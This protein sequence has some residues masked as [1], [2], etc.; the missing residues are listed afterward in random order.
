MQK[1][2]N[3]WYIKL[4]SLLKLETTTRHGRTNLAGVI[5]VMMFCLIYT[6]SDVIRHAISSTE[7]VIKSVALNQDIHHEYESANVNVVVIPILIAF[8]FCLLFLTWHEHK[9]K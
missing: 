1:N 3:R 5:I 9:K 6:A 4:L 8:V 2:N 7:N